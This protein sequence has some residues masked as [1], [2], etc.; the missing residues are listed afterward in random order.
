MDTEYLKILGLYS[1]TLNVE[2]N[3][4]MSLMIQ[5]KSMVISIDPYFLSFVSH[6]ICLNLGKDISIHEVSLLVLG[7]TLYVH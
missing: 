6:Y 5:N 2:S 4:L 3:N 1:Y 7:I